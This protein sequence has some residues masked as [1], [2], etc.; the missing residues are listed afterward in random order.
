MLSLSIPT[1][2]IPHLISIKKHCG[3]PYAH[4]LSGSQTVEGHLA[5]SSFPPF[6]IKSSVLMKAFQPLSRSFP[7]LVLHRS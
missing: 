4:R 6:I 7:A 1:L 2:A 5:F 3:T